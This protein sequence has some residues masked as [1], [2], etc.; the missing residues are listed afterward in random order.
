MNRQA[1]LDALRG[2]AGALSEEE[3]ARLIDYYAEMI[4][5][6]MEEGLSEDAAVADLGDP[7]ELVRDLVSAQ[8]APSAS[9]QERS[10]TV[11]ALRD[12]RIRVF[13]ADVA[14][15]RA[16]LANGA[17]AQLRFSDP[18][19][20]TWRMAGDALEI[21]E[22]EG[23]R[24]G[25]FRLKQPT[26]TLTL[27]GRLPG[28]LT[29]EGRGGDLR[30]DGVELGGDLAITSSSGDINLSDVTCASE[31]GFSLRSGNLSMTRVAAHGALRA[32]ALSG[33]IEV[34]R[35]SVDDDA[36]L[37]TTSGDITLREV[38]CGAL[39]LAATSGDIELDRGHA[40]A[41]SVHTSSGDVWL[42]ELESDPTL[43][44]ETASGDIDLARSI[45][46]ETVLQTASGD[47]DLRLSPLPCGYDIAADTRSGDIQLP[48]NNP[49]AQPGA[50]QPRIA[51]R[52]ASGDID[53]RIAEA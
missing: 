51:I 45:A 36:W 46:V 34:L 31:I 47:V 11:D 42:I 20:Y 22:N 1:F 39:T 3:R 10:E 17:A 8:P 19:H 27:S 48:R 28:A 6:R 18:G 33:D 50:R 25:F 52:T 26:V 29:F 37:R 21:S 24:R 16:P 32:E 35:L 38:R 30:L 7:A 13:D 14:V 15:I 9:R 5:D 49:P 43:S 12:V 53:A 23:Q 2:L 40:L 41:T 4:D 44:V